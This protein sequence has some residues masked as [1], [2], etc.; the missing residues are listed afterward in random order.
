M[1]PGDKPDV[2]R[3]FSAT[4]LT[5]PFGGEVVVL[6]VPWLITHWRTGEHPNPV[7]IRIVGAAFIAIGSIVNVAVLVQF[8]LERSD[9]SCSTDESPSGHIMVSGLYRYVRNPMYGSYM[10]T[11]VGEALLLTRPILLVYAGALFAAL[12]L[13]VRLYEERMMAS[14]F[15]SSYAV[16]RA[17]VPRWWPRL[18]RHRGRDLVG[19]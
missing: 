18:R 9:L 1:E 11:L 8:L 19:P 4:L 15:G 3:A 2:R 13:V 12:M 7:A 10:I 17:S 14:R 16:Y 5:V 6:L